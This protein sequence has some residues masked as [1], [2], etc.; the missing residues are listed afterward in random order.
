MFGAAESAVGD[1]CRWLR[2][3]NQ[4]TRCVPDTWLPVF[5]ETSGGAEAVLS[6]LVVRKRL[7]VC[8]RRW[9]LCTSSSRRHES[10]QPIR[11]A[12]FRVIRANSVNPSSRHLSAR[13]TGYT[14]MQIAAAMRLNLR[15]LNDCFCLSVIARIPSGFGAKFVKLSAWPWQSTALATVTESKPKKLSRP[16]QM[17]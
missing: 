12:C 7:S 13:T 5:F 6:V 8:P 3:C 17:S 9:R 2:P 14:S 15:S 10:L 1:G 11:S 4:E 16:A